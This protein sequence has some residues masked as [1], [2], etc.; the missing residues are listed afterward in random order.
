MSRLDDDF[1]WQC[2]L[3]ESSSFLD[4]RQKLQ[5]KVSRNLRNFPKNI[6]VVFH[7]THFNRSSIEK[8][9]DISWPSNWPVWYF[10]KIRI[11]SALNRSLKAANMTLIFLLSN[12][13]P[14]F[15]KLLD[16]NRATNFA[17]FLNWLSTSDT[18]IT[19]WRM[20]SFSLCI[21]M[22]QQFKVSFAL[23]KL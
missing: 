13:S 5:Y 21:Q 14:A 18:L 17:L 3:M 8:V 4:F 1:F 2:S 11:I 10:W 22:R 9:N 15:F 7:F 23:D 20:M 6:K 16:M 19:W 12:A